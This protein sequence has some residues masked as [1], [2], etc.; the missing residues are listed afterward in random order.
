[1]SARAPKARNSLAVIV[2]RRIFTIQYDKTAQTSAF[3]IWPDSAAIGIWNSGLTER[4]ECA[5]TE[6]EKPQEFHYCPI[7]GAN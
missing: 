2:A 4:I 6:K 5:G 3:R 1:M 7:P